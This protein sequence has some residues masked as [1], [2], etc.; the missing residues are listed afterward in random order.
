MNLDSSFLSF[1]CI[2]DDISVNNLWL[3]F[4]ERILTLMDAHVPSTLSSKLKKREKP[5]ITGELICMIRRRQ[6]TF[7]RYCKNKSEDNF[8]KL[9]DLTSQYKKKLRECQRTFFQGLTLDLQ[10]NKKF[11]KF[12][13]RCGKDKL[14]PPS[15]MQHE[16][17]VVTNDYDKATLFNDFF[18]SVFLPDENVSLQMVSDQ[19][20]GMPQVEF[21]ING[22]NKLLVNI[23][24]SKAT[25]WS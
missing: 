5:W 3:T 7:T 1:E 6:R 19:Y 18:K 12:M 4:K 22:I 2:A 8:C 9:R 11:W 16:G 13:K 21:S 10:S 24:E 25:Y 14:G 15:Q 20:V 23:D 17:F